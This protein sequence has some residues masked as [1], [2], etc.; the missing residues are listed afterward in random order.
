MSEG[1]LNSSTPSSARRQPRW[2]AVF[3]SLLLLAAVG[4]VLVTP[5]VDGFEPSIYAAYPLAFWALLLSTLVLGQ[6]LILREATADSPDHTNWRVGSLLALLVGAILLFLPVI[7][8]YP[9][10]GRADLLTHLGHVSLIEETGGDPFL[11]IYQNLHQFVLAVSYAT[12]LGPTQVVNIVAGVLS[13]F[14]LVASV[15]LL[16]A[17]FDRQRV[18]MTLPF[19]VVLFGGSAHLNPSPF[20]Q[21]ILLV[22]FVLYLFVR[23]Q[24]T[25]A[26]VFRLPLTVATIAVILYHPLTA[27]FVL[28]IFGIHY[29]VVFRSDAADG[30]AGT[31]KLSRV[32]ATS[33]VQLSA[34]TFLAW[35]YNFVGI[36]L[37]F[38]TVFRRLL[39]PSQSQT[40]LDT[41]GQT[42]SQFSPS[43]VDIARVGAFRFG[44][45]AAL[46]G[47]GA[48]FVVVAIW[49]YAR[50][51]RFETPYLLTFVLGF[52]AFAALGVLFLFVDLIGG[53]GR[54]L[55]LAQLFAVLLAGSLLAYLYEGLDSERAV[56]VLAIALF[57]ALG[58]VTIITLYQTPM[59]GSSTNQVT[60]EDFAGAEWYLVNDLQTAPLQEY[61]TSL[62]RFEDAMVNSDAGTVPRE[63]TPPPDGFNY[64]VHGTLGASYDEDVFLVVTDR[65]REFYPNAYPGY[66]EDWRF[67]PTDFERLSQDPTVSHIYSNSE[68]DIYYVEAA[69]S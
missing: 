10:Y 55:M 19:V 36:I 3:A 20:P 62:Y 40:E 59:A 69:D 26:F 25:E 18:L 27:L 32:T 15:A 24:Q 11:N 61:G 58:T 51:N 64:S 13:L 41:Y 47:L 4:I 50:G 60:Q 30:L 28:A 17:L 22:P 56:T 46:L 66:E 65:G 14:A 23:A 42:I 12:G 53:F 16:S 34:V 29:A 63:A 43:T 21:S 44:Q 45:R 37:R 5:A 54:P 7:R 33:I 67:Q 35:Y 57:V 48:A 31:S 68:F 8:G 6:F 52:T 39:N 1:I 2:L 9:L 38:E 49:R